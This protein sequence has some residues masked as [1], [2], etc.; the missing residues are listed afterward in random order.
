MARNGLQQAKNGLKRGKIVGG[1]RPK[2]GQNGQNVEKKSQNMAKLDQKWTHKTPLK[3]G[4]KRIQNANILPK[5]GVNGQR[6]EKEPKFAKRGRVKLGQL[7][8]HKV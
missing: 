1:K 6:G 7:C 4:L 3:R 5:N 2:N 8:E